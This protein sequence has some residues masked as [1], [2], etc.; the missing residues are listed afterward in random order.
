MMTSHWMNP[1]TAIICGNENRETATIIVAAYRMDREKNP[2]ILQ[3]IE[4]AIDLR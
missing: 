1:S 4:S 3:Y 2:E